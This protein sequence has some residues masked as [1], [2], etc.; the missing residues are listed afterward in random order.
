MLEFYCV[1]VMM[2]KSIL[3]PVD[4]EVILPADVTIIL[5]LYV[6]LGLVEGAKST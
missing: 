2:F 6:M 1:N 5:M 3:A 4:P